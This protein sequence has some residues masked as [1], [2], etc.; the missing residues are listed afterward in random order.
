MSSQ[1]TFAMLRDKHGIMERLRVVVIGM[2]AALLVIIVGFSVQYVM[3]KRDVVAAT[4][5]YTPSVAFSN[6]QLQADVAGVF[7]NQS[8]TRTMV[9]L[10]LDKEAEINPNAENYQAYITAV[11]NKLVPQKM[12]TQFSGR[13][14]SF[15]TANTIAVVF[16]APEGFESQVWQLRLVDTA[17]PRSEEAVAPTGDGS[18]PT[19]D[20]IMAMINPGAAEVTVSEALDGDTFDA[21]KVYLSLIMM[22]EEYDMRLKAA[23]QLG[24]MKTALESIADAQRSIEKLQVSIDGEQVGV[25]P[26]DPPV[27]I[28]GDRIE[29]MTSIDISAIVANPTEETYAPYKEYLAGLSERAAYYDEYAISEEGWNTLRLTT[30][31]ILPGG[32]N[33]DW[34]KVSFSDGYLRRVIPD[35]MS[36]TEFFREKRNEEPLR[37]ELSAKDV[38]LTNGKRLEDIDTTDSVNGA[39]I[40]RLQTA[41]SNLISAYE[42]YYTLKSDY[43]ISMLGDFLNRERAAQDATQIVT[44]HNSDDAVVI[45]GMRG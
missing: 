27:A 41:A 32:F 13:I 24:K 15:G 30:E 9:V 35:G 31:T 22:D 25:L 12:K 16:D 18:D 45:N 4:A 23:V 44:V 17:G 7:R 11:N 26:I 1:S 3:S 20:N 19:R 28:E 37:F 36:E 39:N 38:Y 29:G 2:T 43:Q 42:K 14:Y 33:Y 10:R 5:I 6:S 21:S 8:G 40:G 34:R